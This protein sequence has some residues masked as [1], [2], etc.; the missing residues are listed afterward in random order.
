[1]LAA[2]V[3]KPLLWINGIGY[4]PAVLLVRLFSPPLTTEEIKQDFEG[5]LVRHLLFKSKLR[6]F[7]Y[8]T[9]L[10]QGPIRD[11]DVCALGQWIR[12]RRSGLYAGLPEM[13]QL[14]RLHRHV[15]ERANRL[16][17]LRL[18]GQAEAG[19]AGLADVQPLADQITH[20]LTTMQ[21]QLQAQAD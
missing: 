1:M 3:T 4:L 9:N 6:S 15:H 14:D 8:G 13:A 5:A 16:M 2:D 17:D 18:A 7:L 19:I 12:E 21:T 20:L 11:P 10:A